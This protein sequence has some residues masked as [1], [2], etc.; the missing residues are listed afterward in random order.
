MD[1][2]KKN[3]NNST[4]ILVIYGKL[5]NISKAPV[6]E[7]VDMPIQLM[8]IIIITDASLRRRYRTKPGLNLPL[9][10]DLIMPIYY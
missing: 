4:N 10:I 3:N 5:N 6:S 7:P 2:T 9:S 8:F 1:I